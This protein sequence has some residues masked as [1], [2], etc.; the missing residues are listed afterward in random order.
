MVIPVPDLL[1][2]PPQEEHVVENLINISVAAYNGCPSDSTVSL[3]LHFPHTTAIALADTG[4]TNTFMDYQFARKHKIPLSKTRQRSIKVAGGGILSSKFMAYN[5]PFSVQGHKFSVDFRILE[6]QGFDPILGVNWF[7]TY[8][9][10]TF[11][12]IG[13][14][15]T[16]GING[17]LHTF[18][19]HIF[20]RDKFLISSDQCSKLIEQGSLGYMIFSSC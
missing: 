18:H 8:N 5:C 10:V 15:L 20:P 16:I 2:K 4:S 7:T 9:P 6:L 17:Y 1:N 11:D 19:D 12:F 13:R 3:L 14:S